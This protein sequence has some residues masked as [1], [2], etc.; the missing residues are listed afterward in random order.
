MGHGTARVGHFTC[1]EEYQVVSNATRS[2]NYFLKTCARSFL[3]LFIITKKQ[4]KM[5]KEDATGN[6]FTP[7]KIKL[8]EE[9]LRT[10]KLNGKDV[11]N[12]FSVARELGTSVGRI[13]KWHLEQS[14][15]NAQEKD[16]ALHEL[17][18]LQ[19]KTQNEL[20]GQIVKVALGIILGVGVITTGLYILALVKGY[21][22]KIIES[23]WSNMFS[24]LLTNSFSI[25][26]TI[27]GVKYANSKK[28]E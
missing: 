9:Y 23:T 13:N 1:N 2:T 18:V 3:L 8:Y 20:V 17:D 7:D 27:M 5:G 15:K 12:Q 6:E 28:D 16:D 22:V 10:G 26:G 14:Q 19:K 25:I 11:E 4:H 24:I 21:E